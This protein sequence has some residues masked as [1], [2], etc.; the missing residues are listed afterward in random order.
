[1]N[2]LLLLALLQD[3]PKE[4]LTLTAV[5]ERA[6]VVLGDEIQ[7]EVRLENTGDKDLEVS[8]LTFEKRSVSLDI[9]MPVGGGK[10][11]R[12]FTYA[13]VRPDPHVANR[14]NLPKVN[15]AKGKALSYAL[16]IPALKVGDTYITAKY[17]G[18]EKEIKA[19]AQKIVVKP[20]EKGGSIAAIL[21]TDKGLVTIELRPEEAPANVM[22]FVALARSG[23]YDRM[24]F[25]R[26]I[27]GSWVQTGCPYG[28]GIGGPG[29]AIA[30]EA[31]AGDG[32]QQET[33]HELGTVSMCGFE[34]SDFNGSQFF[35]CLGKIP[36]LDGKFTA[37]GKVADETSLKVLADLG[38]AD[39]DKNT[40]R[41]KTDQE[42]KKVSIVVK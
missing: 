20:T 21:E 41:P 22:N 40:D 38:K 1:M 13:I 27:R 10:P 25:H 12:E 14:L 33:R 11:D 6:E 24:I 37:I 28:L 29:Y 23:F 16:R 42:L 5:P 18:G 15:L 30:S 32:R 3:P 8:E 17:A 31:K 26:V 35:I 36:A 9:K 2:W 39:T 34:K 4:P 7:L 19:A